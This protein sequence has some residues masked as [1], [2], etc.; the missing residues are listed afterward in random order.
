MD[1]QFNIRKEFHFQ[2]R[3]LELEDIFSA[4]TIDRAFD[5]L[6]RSGEIEAKKQSDSPKATQTYYG[7]GEQSTEKAEQ[8]LELLI[9]QHQDAAGKI[10][11]FS[12]IHRKQLAILTRIYFALLHK[13]D[14][15]AVAKR[16][17]NKATK[18][19]PEET[20]HSPLVHIAV[21]AGLPL[22]FSLIR[23]S[24]QRND[25]QICEEVFL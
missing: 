8:F 7:F 2:W 15:K 10:T 9:E 3:N 22:L 4:E 6:T 24:W 14:Q 18:P 1:I 25:S 11:P 21:K 5:L 13:P 17:R 19:K 12:S 16:R 20:K 23:R